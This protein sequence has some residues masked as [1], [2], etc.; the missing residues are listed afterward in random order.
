MSAHAGRDGL[1][2]EL[3]VRWRILRFELGQN[4][5]AGCDE[6]FHLG[7][8]SIAV[9]AASGHGF[10]AQTGLGQDL[11]VVAAATEAEQEQGQQGGDGAGSAGVTRRRSE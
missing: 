6:V 1:L 4:G 11:A 9:I 2:P 8:Q 7:R 5:G 10:Q 3:G